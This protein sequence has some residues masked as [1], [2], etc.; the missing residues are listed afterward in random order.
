MIFRSLPLF[1]ITGS[2]INR[3]NTYRY[4]VRVFSRNDLKADISPDDRVRQDP[5]VPTSVST[6]SYPIPPRLE[7]VIKDRILLLCRIHDVPRLVTTE[8]F[9]N[10][11]K[12]LGSSFYSRTQIQSNKIK[13][14]QLHELRIQNI[15]QN[16]RY[17][18]RYNVSVFYFPSVIPFRMFFFPSELFPFSFSRLCQSRD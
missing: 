16:D 11:E 12:M 9:R 14:W 13:A 17:S 2:V 6:P 10:L 3:L 1:D 7:I 4:G 8:H 15:Y 18:F 5:S